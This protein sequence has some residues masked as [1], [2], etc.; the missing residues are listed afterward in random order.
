MR[1]DISKPEGNTL[2]ALGHA[3]RFLKGAGTPA[4]YITELKLA[5][6][7]ATSAVEARHIIEQRTGGAITFVNSAGA[8]T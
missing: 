3:V 4:A 2:A 1:I 5:V 7:R 8:K 6:F